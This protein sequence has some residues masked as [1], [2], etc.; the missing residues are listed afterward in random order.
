MFGGLFFVNVIP[1]NEHVFAR[2][3]RHNIN[4]SKRG[5]KDCKFRIE[6]QVAKHGS[7][8]FFIWLQFWLRFL[9]LFFAIR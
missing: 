1:L 3:S 4:E 8:S 9:F 2:Y 6:R 7:V 5:G